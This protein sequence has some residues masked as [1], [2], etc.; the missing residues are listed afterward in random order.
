MDG[1]VKELPE[2][3]RNLLSVWA[4]IRI[5]LLPGKQIVQQTS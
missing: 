4:K 1:S 5:F 3:Y 2:F